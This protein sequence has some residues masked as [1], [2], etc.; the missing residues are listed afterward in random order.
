M[1]GPSSGRRRSHSEQAPRARRAGAPHVLEIRVVHGSLE[2]ADFPVAV[3]HYQGMPLDGAEGYLDR[4]LG[5]R[6]SEQ[7]LLGVYAEQEGSAVVVPGPPGCA[8][9]GGIVLGLGATGDVTTGTVTLAM[10]RAA[11]LL[12]MA[13]AADAPGDNKPVVIGLSTVLIGANPLDG[14]S[15]E[16]SLAAVVDGVAVAALELA[17][18]PRLNA[19]V[20]IETVEVIE[21]YEARAEAALHA[22]STSIV[23]KRRGVLLR[24]A[25][26]LVHRTG[27]LPGD[28]EAGYSDGSWLRID[29]RAAPGAPAADGYRR[30]EFTSVSRRA[31]AD[32]IE[33][34][35]EDATVDG[36]VSDAVVLVRPDPQT[37]NTLY[38]L[39]V[40]NELKP[41]LESADNLQLLLEPET[42]GYPWEALAP[43]DSEGTAVPLA[44]GAGM[45]RQFADP[46]T[47]NARFDV[48]RAVGLNAL[49]IGNP[50]TGEGAPDLPG[51]A[52]EARGV[53]R[54]LR[55]AASEV[56]A[57]AV[58]ELI[59]QDGVARAVGLPAVEDAESWAHVVNALY[60]HGYRIVHIAAHGAFD[61]AQPAQSGILVGPDRF[62]TAQ[63]FAQLRAVPELVFLNCC[64]SGAIAGPGTAQRLAA[65]V[66]RELIAIGTRAVVAAGWAVEEKGAVAFASTFYEQMLGQG[67]GFGD[68]VHAARAK[69]RDSS[70]SMT[71]AAYQCYG[72]PAFRLREPAN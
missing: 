36:F 60:S 27:G 37:A 31:R 41:D 67:A 3:G 10:T 40:P 1:T 69:A 34:T 57:W 47:R 28:V 21:R 13:A 68:A 32:R 6:L 50:P 25:T 39:L 14:I 20:R 62:L 38:E 9:P 17:A 5:G 72:D 71:W 63:T 18:S 55:R 51:A 56:P 48:Q 15:I 2:H 22:L 30:L 7:L 12:A 70:D 19:T 46:E 43:H 54:L 64:H 65:S 4:C 44:I 8:P 16:R 29:I 11:L 49:V 59:W 61:P 33:Q 53:A 23:P 45:L 58:H 26:A 52:A 24:P 35:L 66:A 42:A